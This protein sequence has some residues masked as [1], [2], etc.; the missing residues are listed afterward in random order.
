MRKT[1]ALR[2][3]LFTAVI[4][5][6]VACDVP[7]VEPPAGAEREGDAEAQAAATEAEADAAERARPR[8]NPTGPAETLEPSVEPQLQG[9]ASVARL[10]AMESQNAKL[11]STAGGDPAINGLY[12]YF[13]L[14]LGPAEGWQVFQIGDFE[15]WTVLSERQGRVVIEARESTLNPDTGLAMTRTRRI[16]IGFDPRQSD[17]ITVTPG[18]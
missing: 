15:D 11:F 12:T 1:D 8:T 14:F 4:G 6:L 13:A 10:H 9:P 17:S 5:L 3:F 16:I 2:G 7:Q 18:S